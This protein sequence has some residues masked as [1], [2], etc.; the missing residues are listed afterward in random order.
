MRCPYCDKEI[1]GITCPACG[2]KIP[3]ESRYCLYCGTAIKEDSPAEETL[4]PVEEADGFDFENRIPC[5]DGRCIGIII[6]GRCN[7]CG[8]RLREK[9]K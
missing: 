2:E 8:K 1:Q 7:I 5:S 9:K 4:A 3:T 6:G